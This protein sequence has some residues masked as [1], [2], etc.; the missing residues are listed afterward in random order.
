MHNLRGVSI[1]FS[2]DF[3]GPLQ[4]KTVLVSAGKKIRA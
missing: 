1:D 2:P 4:G 3:Y